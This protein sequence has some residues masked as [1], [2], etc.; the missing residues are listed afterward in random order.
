MAATIINLSDDWQELRR[1]HQYVSKDVPSIGLKSRSGYPKTHA[2]AVAHQADKKAVR[3]RF[4]ALVKLALS[5][6]SA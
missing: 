1:L 5:T 3:G 4:D 6:P 2:G